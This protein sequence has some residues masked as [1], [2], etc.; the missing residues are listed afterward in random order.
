MLNHV[1]KFAHCKTRS[2]FVQVKKNHNIKKIHRAR[3]FSITET[4]RRAKDKNIEKK[5]KISK[6]LKKEKTCFESQ[7]Y[8]LYN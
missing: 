7:L 5:S 2:K 1:P 8:K 4:P 6:I 3:S